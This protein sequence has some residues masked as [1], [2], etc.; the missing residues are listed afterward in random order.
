MCTS[1]HL[2]AFEPNCLRDSLS[3]FVSGEIAAGSSAEMSSSTSDFNGIV[4]G[5]LEMQRVDE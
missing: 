2:G 1:H 4:A 5:G 3:A